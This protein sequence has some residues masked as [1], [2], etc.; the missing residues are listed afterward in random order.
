MKLFKDK[1]KYAFRGLK[2]GLKDK[3]ICIQFF[4][5]FLAIVLGFISQFD[6][7]KWCI[8]LLCCMSIVTFEFINTVIEKI[9]DFIHPEYHEKIK[10][11]KDMSAGFVLLA[12]MIVL[13]IGIL[14]F[15]SSFYQIIR[16]I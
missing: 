8:L 12:S 14:L 10:D 11:I 9:V 4:F 5:M 2:L 6:L 1:F 15:V 3:S 13:I 7:E 16:G